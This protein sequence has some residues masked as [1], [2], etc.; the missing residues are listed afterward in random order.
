[1]LLP[2]LTASPRRRRW[3]VVLAVVALVAALA[4]RP[5]Y[6]VVKHRRAA[7]LAQQAGQ[8]LGQ[9][10]WLDAARTAHA[11]LQLHH[12]Q[13]LAPLILA[14]SLGAL[15]QDSALAYWKLALAR[16]AAPALRLEAAQAALQLGRPD[17]AEP[18][19][20]EALARQPDDG[21][22]LRLAAVVCDLRG[23]PAAAA[24]HARSALARLPGDVE[25]ELLLCR[26]LAVSRQPAEIAEAKSRLL[27]LARSQPALAP[28]AV[29]L[30]LGFS[31]LTRNE[32][33]DAW[34]LASALPAATPGA[35]LLAAEAHLR[36]EPPKR[37]AILQSLVAARAV[38]PLPAR[39]ELAR[40]LLRQ[41]EFARALEVLPLDTAVTNEDAFLVF[42]DAMAALGRWKELA[43]VLARSGLPLDPALVELYRA[44]AARELGQDRIASLHWGVA[45]SLAAA[46]P[47]LLWHVAQY[48]ERLG[49]Y[50]EAVKA[51]RKLTG[52]RAGARPVFEALV[53]VLQRAGDL[54]QL[55]A[56][57]REMTELFP[58]DPAVR[59][60]DAWFSLLL[61]EDIARARETALAL[62]KQQPQVP[63]FRITLAL[64]HLRAGDAASAL[65]QLD[66]LPLDW[67]QVL[68]AWQAVRV[69]ALG[70]GGRE[71]EARRLASA[72]DLKRF[73]PAE[74]EL[75]W[76]WRG[77]PQK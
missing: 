13:P 23:D 29:S 12:E 46:N 44:R 35:A 74:Q 63:A 16:D 14:R 69:A 70:A 27:N 7:N 55:R 59:N 15:R 24:R 65:A 73:R 66:A 40:W 8:F 47:A 19:V 75:V 68:P 32:L 45:Q 37:H 48:A 11:A 3:L 36:I 56:V 67:A 50:D 39:V 51:L 62:V 77:A 33:Y 17:V 49:E 22:A 41:R 60:D 25:L 42:L 58:D 64:A 53:R 6:R 26:Q 61:R 30:L 34:R 57:L 18:R 20:A 2:D 71:E 38:A 28:A 52:Q 5:V 31:D 43:D 76:P 21:A 9:K 54:P 10:Q 1:M 4:A 72:L